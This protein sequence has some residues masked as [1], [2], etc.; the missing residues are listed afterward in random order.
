VI[1]CEVLQQFQR[2]FEPEI[3]AW[4]ED[5]IAFEAV[6][7]VGPQGHF[8]G[9]EHMQNRYETA[10]YGPFL[11]DWRNY[12]AWSEAG[13]VWTDEC[14]NRICKAILTEFEPPP[15]D[16]AIREEL[17]EFVARRK[18]EGGAPTEY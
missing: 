10:S 6:R 15:M 17:T 7:E 2:Y 16:A 4:D 8:F 9:A 12:E 14:A 11:S 1:D 5:A 13:A 3:T 18:R